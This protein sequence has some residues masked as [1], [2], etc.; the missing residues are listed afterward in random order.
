MY[1]DE[2]ERKPITL[3]EL[4]E[5]AGRPLQEVD[6]PEARDEIDRLNNKKFA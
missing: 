3:D 2:W 6:Y 5:V 4:W 1:R